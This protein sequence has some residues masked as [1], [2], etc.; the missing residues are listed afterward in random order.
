MKI[1]IEL[2]AMAIKKLEEAAVNAAVKTM[3]ALYGDVV[4]AQVMPFDLGD[5]QNNQTFTAVE[6]DSNGVVV[7]LV[8]GSPQARRLYYHP[9]YNFQTVNNPN[10]KGLWLADWVEGDK[11]DLI[12]K[13]LRNSTKRRLTYDY[14]TVKVTYRYGDNTI[15]AKSILCIKKPG[16]LPGLSSIIS[17][18]LPHPKQRLLL[19]L[20]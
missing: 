3:E 6:P 13:L 18:S 10:A 14:L 1:R 8:T 7:R 9:E 2:D 19:L 17:K 20:Q 11:S 12:E 16:N 15:Q 5:M 4:S